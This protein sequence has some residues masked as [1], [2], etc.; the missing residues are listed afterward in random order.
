MA[1][2]TGVNIQLVNGGGSTG[3]INTINGLG[4]LI[5]GYDLPRDASPSECSDGQYSDQL[6]CEGAGQ[7]W[8]MSHKTGSHY[9]VIGDWNNYSQFVGLVVG[10]QNAVNGPFSSVTMGKWN[11]ASGWF[12]S[13]SGGADDTAGEVTPA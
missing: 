5:I 12:S 11:R 7:T 3:A 6:A 4:N 1:R 2:F 10:R 13:V 8:A 9:L